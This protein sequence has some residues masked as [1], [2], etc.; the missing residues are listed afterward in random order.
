MVSYWR[1]ECQSSG[2]QIW[3]LLA[4]EVSIFFMYIPR[5]VQRLVLFSVTGI[6]VTLILSGKV[7]ATTFEKV[8]FEKESP[9]QTVYVTRHD[10]MVNLRTGSKFASSSA[11]DKSNPYRHVFEYTELMMMGLSYVDNPENALII[12]LGG[13]TL[14]KYLNKY[15]PDLKIDN[16]EMDPVVVNVAREYFD[17][18]ES[19]TNQVYV[20][21]GRRFLQKTDK[22]YDLIFLDAYYGSYIPF[23]LLTR[24][25]LNLVKSRLSE[26]GVAVSNTW[27]SPG[28]YERESATWADVFGNF[29]SYLGRRSGNRVVIATNSGI[30]YSEQELI[31]LMKSAQKERGFEEINLPVLALSTLDRDPVW[32][33]DTQLLTDDFAPVNLLVDPRHRSTN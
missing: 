4:S 16:I 8:V 17:F 24:E 9:Y 1:A 25:F 28:L 10:S 30:R 15:Y 18:A 21:D 31:A 22:K 27:R 26:K 3:Y 23:H 2:N 33:A 32:P 12:G 14:T 19:R 5:F 13:G 7:F 20:M 29:D 6:C 11:L